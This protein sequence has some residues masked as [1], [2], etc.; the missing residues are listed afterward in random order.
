MCQEY[1]FNILDT[2]I[3]L[4]LKGCDSSVRLSPIS[5]GKFREMRLELEDLYEEARYI[6]HTLYGT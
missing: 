5:L 1:K 2:C 3:N 6:H 4:F